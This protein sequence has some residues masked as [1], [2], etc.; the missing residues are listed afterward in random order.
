MRNRSDPSTSKLIVCATEAA[1]RARTRPTSES[2]AIG[3]TIC[4][5]ASGLSAAACANW[6]VWSWRWKNELIRNHGF[7]RFSF[8]SFAISAG[9][10]VARVDISHVFAP[11]SP[12]DSLRRNSACTSLANGTPSATSSASRN[13]RSCSNTR[14]E[15]PMSDF[16]EEFRAAFSSGICWSSNTRCITFT[17]SDSAPSRFWPVRSVRNTSSSMWTRVDSVIL[18]PSK[19][20][21]IAC[22]GPSVTCR[23]PSAISRELGTD[24]CGSS[25]WNEPG[26]SA[27]LRRNVSVDAFAFAIDNGSPAR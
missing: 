25:P 3:R 22:V 10:W 7:D 15:L 8:A 16:T 20:P 2:A 23:K 12:C 27:G 14:A 21:P 5:T 9:Y 11:G 24:T 26:L 6:K 1:L 18:S 19:S 4:P 13:R 17:G